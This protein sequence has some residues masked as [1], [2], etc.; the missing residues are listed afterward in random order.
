M[1]PV[2]AGRR[3]SPYYAGGY[4]DTS[5]NPNQYNNYNNGSYGSYPPSN[6]NAYGAP[7]HSR[8]PS[9]VTLLKPPSLD[10]GLALETRVGLNGARDG[11][12]GP[13]LGRSS[14]L[15]PMEEADVRKDP[16]FRD[17]ARTPPPTPD[18]VKFLTDKGGIDWQKLRTKEYW[19]K[20]ETISEYSLS[21]VVE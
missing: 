14:D 9:S 18:E 10:E 6:A 19:M 8:D 13:G 12:M 3:G 15:E 5:Y 16:R 2:G 20:K 4:N 1:N 7:S 17:G 21:G 11:S